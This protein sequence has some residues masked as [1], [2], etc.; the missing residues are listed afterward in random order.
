MQLM[1]FARICGVHCARD[2]V[3]EA[4]EGHVVAES[5]FEHQI[6]DMCSSSATHD[7]W[8][9]RRV[10]AL[11]NSVV[12]GD[13]R[14]QAAAVAASR[15]HSECGWRTSV[16]NTLLQ[17][18]LKPGACDCACVSHV[19]S[20]GTCPTVLI[21]PEWPRYATHALWTAFGIVTNGVQ[22][23][24]TGGSWQQELLAYGSAPWMVS[25]VHPSVAD[26]HNFMTLTRYGPDNEV[27]V[28]WQAQW[29]RWHARRARRLWVRFGVVVLL[30]QK[31]ETRIAQHSGHKSSGRVTQCSLQ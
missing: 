5:A 6:R 17:K 4:S 14:R 28:L 29:R 15:L 10:Q 2:V 18:S 26:G 30:D 31:S 16:L 3:L 12:R 24:G 1:Q 21:L 13:V 19:L 11:H 7:T 23:F 20:W 8:T 22:Q 27:H 25:H 9:C